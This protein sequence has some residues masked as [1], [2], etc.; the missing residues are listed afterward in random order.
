MK[1]INFVAPSFEMDSCNTVL[2]QFESVDE[3]LWCDHSNELSVLILNFPMDY[4]F[5]SAVQSEIGKFW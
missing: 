1:E 5:F 3:I 2:T 4:L